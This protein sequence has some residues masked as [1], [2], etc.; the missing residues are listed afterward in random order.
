MIKEYTLNNGLKI[1]I[2]PISSVKSVAM[3]IWVGTGSRNELHNNNG[4]SHFIEH[5]LF[6]GTEK[7]SAKE[8]A[9]SFDNIGGNL[10]AFTSKE[11]TCYY[12]KTLDEHIEVGLEILSDMFFNSVFDEKEIEQEKNVVFE[13]IN[14]TEDTPDD[15]IHDLAASI[16]FANSSLGYP[17][18][19]SKE[20]LKKISR[21]DIMEYM[22]VKYNISNCIVTL[23]GNVNE[24]TIKIIEKYFGKYDNKGLKNQISSAKFNPGEMIKTKQTEQSHMVISLPGLS[25]SDKNLYSLVLANNILGG[26]MSS[27]L[28]QEIREKRGLAYSVFSYH[29]S[30]KDTG[31]FNIYA[32]T[33]SDKV[34]ETIDVIQNTLLEMKKNGITE[35]EISKGKEQLKGSLLL[36]LES[37]TSRMNRLGKNELLRGTQFSLDET[38]ERI[39]SVSF[40]SVHNVIDSVFSHIYSFSMISPYQ[41]VPDSVRRDIFV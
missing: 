10:N 29:S 23:A 1:L 3:G 6:K 39:N 12:A 16:S 17:I 36:S 4:I 41:Q 5:M 8:I 34:N 15:K 32:G 14:M 26:S 35:Q 13:E 22:N 33:K 18:L 31:L 25:I 38:L 21:N 7:R 19:G 2:E 27:R 30:F 28:F 11:Y 9:E 20:I 24:D 37:T 40:E